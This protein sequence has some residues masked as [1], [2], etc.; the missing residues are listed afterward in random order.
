MAEG[1]RVLEVGALDI[2][3]SLRDAISAL[4]PSLYL[5]CDIMLGKGVDVKCEAGNL[6]EIFGCE[7]FDI[8]ISTE[9]LE[10]VQ[11]WRNAI[12]NIKHV[13]KRGGYILITTRSMGFSRHCHPYDYWR[14]EEEDMRKIFA[15]CEI[16]KTEKDIYAPGIFILARKP[17]DFRECFLD[18]VEVS[19]VA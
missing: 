13:T 1:K 8:V 3:G 6:V 14:F 16:I 12:H 4:K 17:H 2:N 15:D 9:M 19:C 11:D 7:T 18:E 10:H 5:G